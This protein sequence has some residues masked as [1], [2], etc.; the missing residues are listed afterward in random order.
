MFGYVISRVQ[1]FDT[2]AANWNF[3]PVYYWQVMFSFV[4]WLFV[5][6]FVLGPL[7]ASDAC[8]FFAAEMT[9]LIYSFMLLGQ[10]IIF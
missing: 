2:D 5:L 6:A 4:M 9:L 1:C 8:N 7:E 10:V 3:I